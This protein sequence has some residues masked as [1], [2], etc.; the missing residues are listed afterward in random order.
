MRVLCY[1]SFALANLGYARTL[2]T[3]LRRYHPDWELVA[4]VADLAQPGFTLELKNEPFDRAV[5][6]AEA[7]AD[8]AIENFAS[9]IFQREAPQACAALKGPFSY[10]ECQR[11]GVDAVVYLDPNVCLFGSLDTLL[12]VLETRDVVVVPGDSGVFAHRI[13][14]DGA[15]FAKWLDGGHSAGVL[16]PLG[17]RT[18]LLRDPGY[19]VDDWNA[20]DADIA[21]EADGSLSVDGSPLRLWRFDGV[22]ARVGTLATHS[23]N[24]NCAVHEVRN[25]YRR[26]VADAT[27]PLLADR[28][29]AYA[30]YDNGEAIEKRHRVLYASDRSL[31]ARFANPFNTN[32]NSYYAWLAGE[33]LMGLS[34]KNTTTEMEAR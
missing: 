14:A 30:S 3:S 13:N 11:P 26:Q 8:L 9:W 7:S 23:A 18:A 19:S 1:S 17:D 10:R 32:R 15:R 16:P 28:Y 27:T 12:D 29:W 31:Q 33:G 22:D 20:A 4:L 6:A 25:W 5:F 2:F 21:F 34:G 24:R